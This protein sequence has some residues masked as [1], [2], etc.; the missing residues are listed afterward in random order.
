MSFTHT[1]KAMEPLFSVLLSAVF[2]GVTPTLPVLL[3]L[4]PIVGGVAL[5]SVSEY[6]FTWLG[7]LLIPHDLFF[8]LRFGGAGKILCQ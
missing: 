2:L 6:S 5:A 3:S 1:V 4:V 7:R 8:F